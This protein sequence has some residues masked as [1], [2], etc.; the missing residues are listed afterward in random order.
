MG[1][2]YKLA[3]GPP[4][5][6]LTFGPPSVRMMYMPDTRVLL[7]DDYKLIRDSLRTLL[8]ASAQV[9]VV[10]EAAD[11]LQAVEMTLRLRPDV[12]VM[13]I[14]MPGLDGREAA[15][16]ITAEAPA[17]RVIAMSMHESAKVVHEALAAGAAGYLLKDRAI[18]EL[19]DAIRVV[20]EGRVYLSP[21]IAH[22]AKRA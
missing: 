2:S 20:K 22:L 7:A 11:G 13:D 12:L 16:R 19:P 3:V 9:E 5:I 1:I 14:S 18:E 4:T 10:G 21:R 8:T 15:R 6:G 17:V